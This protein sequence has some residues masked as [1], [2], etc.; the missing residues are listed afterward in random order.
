MRFWSFFFRK[1]FGW[2][3]TLWSLPLSLLMI[4]EVCDYKECDY[5]AF[6]YMIIDALIIETYIWLYHK[7]DTSSTVFWGV[8]IEFVASPLLGSVFVKRSFLMKQL[9][10]SIWWILAKIWWFSGLETFPK[11]KTP[12]SH[13]TTLGQRWF[14][15]YKF[16][17]T[18]KP[19]WFH[20]KR[21]FSK[22]SLIILIL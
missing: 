22:I 8:I 7:N 1:G 3:K 14:Q 6:Y 21:Q 12:K 15:N 17:T 9:K 19:L 18:V 2:G 16:E 10:P 11:K 4:I 20:K 13:E 5:R